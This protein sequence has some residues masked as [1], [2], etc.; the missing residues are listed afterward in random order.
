MV[1]KSS[2]ESLLGTFAGRCA[3]AAA[4]KPFWVR[5]RQ[6]RDRFVEEADLMAA[7]LAAALRN[8]DESA[9]T[10]YLARTLSDVGGPYWCLSFDHFTKLSPRNQA[11]VLRLLPTVTTAFA[12][13]LMQ[14]A[15]DDAWKQVLAEGFDTVGWLLES[16]LS[17]EADDD[18]RRKVARMDLLVLRDRK[19]PV[20]VGGVPHP[21]HRIVV[22]L[23]V[24][25]TCDDEQFVRVCEDVRKYPEAFK[26]R[27]GHDVTWLAL[28]CDHEGQTHWLDDEWYT[29]HRPAEEE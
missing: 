3:V 13:A 26:E 5:S 16:P 18:G 29:E 17:Y 11:W 24:R 10:D 14:E 1:Q 21:E 8:R 22:D 9:E 19:A 23:K 7:H 28:V 6:G 27:T 15:R 20:P 12:E 25:G 4:G 2:K